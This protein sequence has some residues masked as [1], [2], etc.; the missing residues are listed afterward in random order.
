MANCN[1]T[2]LTVIT[3]T[4]A[5]GSSASPY[6]CTANITK[7]LCRSVCAQETPV[8]AP[9]FAVAG[10]TQVGTGQYVATIQVQGCVTY[11]PCGGSCG[12]SEPL[13][14]T[15]TIPFAST[16]APT[17]VTVAAG[18]TVNAIVTSPCRSCGRTFVSE[19]ALTLT[20]TA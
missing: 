19:T 3:A 4:V 11:T 1:K 6:F 2:S 8:F 9:S 18:N 17:A 15:F 10:W 14:R 5:A 7:R 20:V 13:N 16:S 12:E